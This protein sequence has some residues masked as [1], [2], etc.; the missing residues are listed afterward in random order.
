MVFNFALEYTI[1]N[2]Q[3]NEMGLKSNGTHQLL[4]YVDGESTGG[5]H[6]YYKEKTTTLINTIRAVGLEIN[7]EKIEYILLTRH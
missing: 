1:G 7:V 3:E 5:K 6:R 4:A 2:V